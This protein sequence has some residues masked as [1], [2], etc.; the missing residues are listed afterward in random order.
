MEGGGKGTELDREGREV[1]PGRIEGRRVN[2]IKTCKILILVQ[3]GYKCGINVI[4]FLKMISSV[5]K[6]LAF[7]SLSTQGLRH[8]SFM[9]TIINWPEDTFIF[10][11]R[12]FYTWRIFYLFL[13]LKY[14]FYSKFWWFI[15]K[16]LT[17]LPFFNNTLKETFLYPAG[18]QKAI[19]ICCHNTL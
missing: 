10:P 16:C 14:V 19:T 18:E 11:F 5:K 7:F 2:M 8:P 12:F 17:Y 1:D 9:Q 13:Y 6:C 15:W 3:I 4:S